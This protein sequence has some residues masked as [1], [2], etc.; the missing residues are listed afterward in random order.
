M[1]AVN[2]CQESIVIL[3]EEGEIVASPSIETDRR[4]SSLPQG[5]ARNVRVAVPSISMAG[6]V[7]SPFFLLEPKRAQ[8]SAP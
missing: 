5:A 2:V 7:A 4:V 6:V 3:N 1:V 8:P